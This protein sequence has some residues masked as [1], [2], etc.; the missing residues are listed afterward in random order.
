MGE[1]RFHEVD[2][3]ERWTQKRGNL[4]GNSH[5][6]R[7]GDLGVQYEAS[8]VKRSEKGAFMGVTPK[9]AMVIET[10]KKP[11]FDKGT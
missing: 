4:W 1:K 9:G 10:T 3:A 11:C 7:N 2:V 6:V 5:A 8:A